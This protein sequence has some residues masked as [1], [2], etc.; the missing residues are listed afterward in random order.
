MEVLKRHS[1]PN[2]IKT[3]YIRHNHTFHLNSQQ[4]SYVK[5]IRQTILTHHDYTIINH[6]F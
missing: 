5:P 2:D 3:P 6:R 4:R 1:V